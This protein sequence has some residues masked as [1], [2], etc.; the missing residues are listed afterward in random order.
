MGPG[1]ARCR[2]LKIIKFLLVVDMK[3]KSILSTR[4]K[5]NKISTSCRLESQTYTKI[6]IKNNKISTSCRYSYALCSKM[7]IKNNKISTSCR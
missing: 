1:K 6:E 7:M 5:N 2:R 3:F 4:I